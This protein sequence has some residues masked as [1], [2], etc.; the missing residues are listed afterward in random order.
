MR[1]AGYLA[2][3][4]VYMSAERLPALIAVEKRREDFQWQRRRHKQRV[5]FQRRE[6]QGAEFARRRMILRQL[7]VVFRAR[8]LMSGGD[9]PVNPIGLFQFLTALRGLLGS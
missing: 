1:R 3:G 6:D 2:N 9:A 4:V 5:G 8:R 7:H